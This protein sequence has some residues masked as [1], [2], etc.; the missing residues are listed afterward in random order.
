MSLDAF[1]LILDEE[2][3][4]TDVI[5]SFSLGGASVFKNTMGLIDPTIH[6]KVYRIS[7]VGDRQSSITIPPEATE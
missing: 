6:K 7:S 5:G 4:F 2:V 3:K 1:R